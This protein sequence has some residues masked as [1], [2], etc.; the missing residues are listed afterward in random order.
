M[1]VW[2]NGLFASPWMLLWL[3]AVVAPLV[4]HLL[5]RQRYREISWAA[6]EYLLAAIEKSKR[7]MRIQQWL[8]LL[9]RM[10][11]LLFIVLAM[12]EPLV[13][14]LSPLPLSNGGTHHIF[15]LDKSYSMGYRAENVTDFQRAKKQIVDRIGAGQSGD[16]YSLILMGEQAEIVVGRPSLDLPQF[17]AELDALPVG[18]A[19]ADLDA[20]LEATQNLIDKAGEKGDFSR[21]AVTIVSDLGR[22]T[23]A[24]DLRSDITSSQ[25][26]T[27]LA[28]L[29]KGGSIEVISLG[30]AT[31]NNVAVVDL[32]A[33]DQVATV[34]EP[35]RFIATLHPFTTQSLQGQTVELWVDDVRVDQ[36]K[37]DFPADTD[38]QVTFT[39][40]F[41]DP[42]PHAIRV[43]TVADQL[44]IDDERFLA[45]NVKEKI[46][47]LLVRGKRGATLPLLAAIDG[48]DE[49]L[50]AAKAEVV[51][52]SRVAELDLNR[53]DCIFLCNVAQWTSQEAVRLKEYVEQGGGLVTMLGDQVLADQYNRELFNGTDRQKN[54]GSGEYQSG[55]LPA[56][57]GELF[58]DAN[59]HF[60][61][62]KDYAHPM[63][64]PWKGNPRTGLTSVPVLQY[65][66]LEIPEESSSKTILWLDTGDPLLVLSRIGSGWSLLLAT[67]PTDSSRVATDSERSWSLIASWLNA[68]PFFEGLWK[69][70][71][72]GRR[73][74]SNIE[75]GQWLYGK[76]ATSISPQSVVLEIPDTPPR[77]VKIAVGPH[78]SWSFGGTET[79]G[80]YRLRAEARAEEDVPADSQSG[81]VDAS[82]ATE[83]RVYAVNLD[84]RES[85][86][87]SLS[88]AELSPEWRR[89]A[90]EQTIATVGSS[91]DLAEQRLGTIFLWLVLLLLFLEIFLAW[92]MGNRFA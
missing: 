62:P 15:L 2:L 83:D 4:I 51:D 65:F 34:A 43:R 57:L 71:I 37:V 92:W 40:P 27:R 85:N 72:G 42:G 60:P 59:Y 45:I 23:W 22:T 54:P 19:G 41:I 1:P 8:L 13:R 90:S 30:S 32:V 76:L 87:K 49:T 78:A 68:Q 58:Y 31:R 28:R 18:Q 66:R 20:A 79:R 73:N 6:M 29:A 67:D 82:D 25:R 10:L 11:L 47:I 69:A 12:A 38:T 14:N 36:K 52:E 70:V 86:L 74:Q 35:T 7:R 55:F 9:V 77:A 75:V 26:A 91:Q 84:T 44:P 3:P 39:Y 80:I 21:H 89:Y 56:K 88:L 50:H 16:G 61:D 63:L 24:A 17:L 81:V 5:Y 48:G 64:A 33:V 46:N 53:Y